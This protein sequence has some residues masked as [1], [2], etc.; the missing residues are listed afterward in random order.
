MRLSVYP[1]GLAVIDLVSAWR[2]VKQDS[3]RFVRPSARMCEGNLIP[4]QRL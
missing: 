2:F 4:Y 1:H 3:K